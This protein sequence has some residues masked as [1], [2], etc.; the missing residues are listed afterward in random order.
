[1]VVRSIIIAAILVG[2]LSVFPAAFLFAE[3]P[4]KELPVLVTIRELLADSNKYDGHRVV[5]TGRVRS[6]EGQIGR[7]G[8]E[9]VLLILEDEEAG[10]LEPIPSIT[11][12]SLTLPPVREGHHALVQGSFRKEGRQAGRPFEFFID[13]EVI[14]KEKL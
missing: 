7:R 10:D 9:Y 6:V 13:A 11:V 5:T 2:F 8:S 3:G 12:I 1:M 14:L 4:S